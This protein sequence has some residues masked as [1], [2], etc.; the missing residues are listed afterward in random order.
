MDHFNGR[1]G[2]Q[3]KTGRLVYKTSEGWRSVHPNGITIEDHL[4]ENP[5]SPYARTKEFIIQETA[6]FYFAVDD[7]ALT[8][9]Q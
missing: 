6:Q 1:W 2:I 5:N 9:L 7:I 4:A 3:D 8:F